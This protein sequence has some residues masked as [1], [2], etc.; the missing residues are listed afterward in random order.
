MELLGNID[1]QSIQNTDLQ[2]LLD[3]FPQS[4]I[5]IQMALI[6]LKTP[7]RTS[8]FPKSPTF[9]PKALFLSKIHSESRFSFKAPFSTLTFLYYPSNPFRTSIFPISSIFN[10]DT[11]F[12]PRIP[13]G[14]QLSIKTPL[15]TQPPLSDPTFLPAGQFF[16]KASF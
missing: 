5:F 16:P 14:H 1:L 8:V 3:N 13:T 12:Y 9:N 4:P 7:F 11:S 15:S 2:S 10:P 6:L